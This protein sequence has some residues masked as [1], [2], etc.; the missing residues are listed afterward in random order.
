MGPLHERFYKV[1]FRMSDLRNMWSRLAGKFARV[2]AGG[3]TLSISL[4]C[5]LLLFN[6]QLARTL[7]VSLAF[8]WFWVS[9]SILALFTVWYVSAYIVGLIRWRLDVRAD[10]RQGKRR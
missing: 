3:I 10:A 8:W 5:V 4:P 9:C 6:H 2:M 7:A 1:S